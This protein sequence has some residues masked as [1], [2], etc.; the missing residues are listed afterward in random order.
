M[1]R[2][3]VLRLVHVRVVPAASTGL[4]MVWRWMQCAELPTAMLEIVNQEPNGDIALMYRRYVKT[5]LLPEVQRVADTLRSSASTIEWCGHQKILVPLVPAVLP[6]FGC[7]RCV[8]LLVYR[9]SKV[10]LLE[11]FPHTPWIIY[12]NSSF[13]HNW[14]TYA[15][16][17]EALLDSWIDDAFNNMRPSL[18]LPL[19]ALM[20]CIE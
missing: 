17:L 13:A 2:Q 7:V 16:S 15:R 8:W 1:S 19:A 14:L 6:L 11:N 10:F 4:V 3:A 9:P 20:T 12:P 5:I 18:P